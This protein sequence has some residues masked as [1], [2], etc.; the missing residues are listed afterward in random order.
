VNDF[1]LAR[2]AA[3]ISDDT[4]PDRSPPCVLD[5]AARDPTPIEIMALL[6]GLVG[7]SLAEPRRVSVSDTRRATMNA[8]AE[9]TTDPTK[10]LDDLE[11]EEDGMTRLVEEC[12]DLVVAAFRVARA[13]N[14]GRLPDPRAVTSVARELAA[15]TGYFDVMPS[16]LATSA[17]CTQAGLLR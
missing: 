15:R 6:I 4:R 16:R 3:R 14:A 13:R 9:E 1:I 8:R 7:T 11:R 17:A 2:T 10:W 12:G 5:G